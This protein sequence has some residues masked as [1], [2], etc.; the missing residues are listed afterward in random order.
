MDKIS[1]IV[2]VYNVEAYLPQCIDSIL[3]Q[4]YKNLEI[5]LV[6]DGSTDT[7]LDVCKRYARIDNRIKVISKVN[8]GQSSARNLGL[9]NSTGDF[10]GFVDSD[11]WIEPNMYEVL[12]ETI[13]NYNADIAA[14]AIFNYN[15]KKDTKVKTGNSGETVLYDSF[16]S[17]CDN[18]FI[19]CKHEIRFEIWNKLYKRDILKGIRFKEGQLYEEI[20]FMRHVLERTN[21]LAFIDTPL[22][23][24]RLCRPGSTVSSFN[25][26]RLSKA[27]EIDPY[28]SIFAEHS[29]QLL[30]KKYV[31]YAM[32]AVME[33]YSLACQHNASRQD[34]NVLKKRFTQYYKYAIERSMPVKIRFQVFYYCPKLYIYISLFLSLVR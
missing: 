5:I 34:K 25:I 21:K 31:N 16:N 30:E 20:F 9:E 17:Y 23:N 18:L 8:G 13:Y 24:Y 12:M 14:C 1:I 4:T 6:D 2:P 11:D 7:S 26:S 10:I 3:E 28:I 19:P 32:N 15:Y 22:Y 27:D 29:N 33:L